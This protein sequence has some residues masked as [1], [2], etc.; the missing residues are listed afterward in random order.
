[1]YDTSIMSHWCLWQCSLFKNQQIWNKFLKY[2]EQ[3]QLFTHLSM[4]IE[5]VSYSQMISSCISHQYC[6]RQDYIHIVVIMGFFFCTKG[7]YFKLNLVTNFSPFSQQ[8]M[9]HG[10][11]K[12]LKREICKPCLCKIAEAVKY[13]FYRKNVSVQ[14]QMTEDLYGP[15]EQECKF[16]KLQA[17][18]EDIFL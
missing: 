7:Q 2:F 13:K 3:C 14:N 5:A 11:F 6:V 12:D 4:L 1:M 15:E 8:F 10:Q 9:I 18:R 17:G 16:Q